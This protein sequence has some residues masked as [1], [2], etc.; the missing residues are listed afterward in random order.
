MK[1]K[2]C[3]PYTLAYSPNTIAEKLF[4]S[5]ISNSIKE[6]FPAPFSPTIAENEK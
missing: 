1:C 3:L 4:M 6:L 5:R 2:C